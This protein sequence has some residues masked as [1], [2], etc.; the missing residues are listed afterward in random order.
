MKLQT[1]TY[2]DN[3]NRKFDVN[4]NVD[5]SLIIVFTS[6]NKSIVE[7]P[8]T[9]LV[10]FFSKATII[11][12]SGAGQIAQDELLENSMVVAVLTF[13]SAR[14]KSVSER[15]LSNRE[16]F[17]NGVSISNKLREDDLKAIFL[18][19]DGLIT[20]G[21]KLTKGIASIYGN[22][23]VVT[24]GLA[25][26]NHEFKNTYVIVDGKLTQGYLSAV[27][28]YGEH[29]HVG[30]GSGGGWDNL[31]VKR[32]V[33]K[34]KDNVLYELDSQPAL[35]IYRRYLGEKSSE[36]PSIGVHFPIKLS[37]TFTSKE[38]E[39]NIRTILGID[40]QNKTITF[41]GDI[42]EG[43]YASLMRGNNDRLIDGATLAAEK[44]NL[45]GHGNE[46]IL[47]IAISCVGR[48]F[49]LKQQ[50]EEELEATLEVL[51]QKTMQIGFYAYGE[52]APISSGICDLHNETMTLTVI[53]EDNA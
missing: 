32:L 51:P 2:R 29:I 34:S 41:A 40:E 8:L 50:T 10:S 45:D 25:G 13:R 28:L 11:G 18:L 52:I 7:Q 47:S 17:E 30:H 38:E 20:N 22:T 39:S 31:G 4:L 12:A 19:S 42:D 21:S 35:D 15:L 9:E 37:N 46:D 27:G 36:L 1:Y 48:K 23:I 24:G 49:L 44:V 33:T 43:S 6:A 5:K 16:S 26:D 53:W 3:W 14:I